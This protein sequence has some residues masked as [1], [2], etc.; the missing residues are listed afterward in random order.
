MDRPRLPDVLADDSTPG[1]PSP[2]LGRMLLVLALA[3]LALLVL[4]IVLGL[5]GD[6]GAEDFLGH[7]RADLARQINEVLATLAR[8]A[9]RC[10]WRPG[11]TLCSTPSFC[12]RCTAFSCLRSRGVSMPHLS[13]VA[14]HK[15]VALRCWSLRSRCC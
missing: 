9:R 4:Q 8:S 15:A 14:G 5:P 12:C 6:L 1:G 2:K 11:C 10:A 3:T 13:C 7:G